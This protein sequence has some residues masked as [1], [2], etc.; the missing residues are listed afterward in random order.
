MKILVVHGQKEVFKQ[1]KSVLR[2]NP[3][4]RFSDSGLDGLLAARIEWFDL[5]ICGT[6]LPV[7]TGFEMIR[8]IRTYSANKN[9]SV[10]L[11]VENVT[12]RFRHLS[13]RLG[14][15]ATLGLEELNTRLANVVE[16]LKNTL[17]IF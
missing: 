10:I 7:I 12:G 11:I 3:I 16:E 8:S 14:I 9:A 6:D 13:E 4:I 2:N 5:I 17:D 15:D 1:V